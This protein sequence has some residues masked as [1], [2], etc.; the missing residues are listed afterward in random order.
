MTEDSGSSNTSGVCGIDM[1]KQALKRKEKGVSLPNQA[2]LRE[3][4]N[5]QGEG[6]HLLVCR[7]GN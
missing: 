5:L 7:A 6:G 4:L 1:P 2:G 3:L